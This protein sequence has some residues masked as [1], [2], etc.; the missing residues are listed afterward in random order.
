M[1]RRNLRSQPLPR[2]YP[3]FHRCR[4]PLQCAASLRPVPLLSKLLLKLLLLLLLLFL[5][6]SL[7]MMIVHVPTWCK[8]ADD[9]FTRERSSK[10]REQELTYSICADAV[11]DTASFPQGIHTSTWYSTNSSRAARVLLV[12][13]SDLSPQGSAGTT[14][15]AASLAV[16]EHGSVSSCQHCTALVQA[17]A[18]AALLNCC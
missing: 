15:A 11:G 13:S 1:R 14:A 3:P 2:S 18:A 5:L 6:L 17:S 4:R 16:A 9:R 10:H 12:I 7:R 8:T